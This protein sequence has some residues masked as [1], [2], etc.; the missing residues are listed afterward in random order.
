MTAE[1]KKKLVKRFLY[2][3]DELENSLHEPETYST[4]MCVA[5]NKQDTFQVHLTITKDGMDFLNDGT[6][7]PV[8]LKPGATL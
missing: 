8:I 2:C 3:L 4:V 5:R 1:L 6:M 7:P